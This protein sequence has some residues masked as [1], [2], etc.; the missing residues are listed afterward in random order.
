MNTQTVTKAPL[1]VKESFD[2][3][4]T[5]TSDSRGDKDKGGIANPSLHLLHTLMVASEHW[6]QKRESERLL[7]WLQGKNPPSRCVAVRKGNP[8]DRCMNHSE[9]PNS[10]CREIHKCLSSSAGGCEEMRVGE[11][12][13]CESHGC[14]HVIGFAQCV[15][16]R[17]ENGL[18]C[19]VHSCPCCI[20]DGDCISNLIRIEGSATCSRHRCCGEGSPSD[21]L[22]HTCRSPPLSPHAYCEAHLCVTCGLTDS[23]YNLPRLDGSAFCMQHKCSAVQC[24]D[25]RRGDF[26]Y[27]DK[28]ICRICEADS[29]D[30]QTI[31][32]TAPDSHICSTHRCATD[33]CCNPKLS[34]T[35]DRSSAFCKEHT[36]RVC[37]LS[38]EACDRPV[39]DEYPRNVCTDHPLCTHFALQG[40]QCGAL[41]V[42]P[43]LIKCAKHDAD[44]NIEHTVAEAIMGD[45]QCWGIAK[46]TH[47]RCKSTGLDPLGGQYWCHHHLAQA[48]V[49]TV[50]VAAPV[51]EE[52]EEIDEYELLVECCQPSVP[53]PLEPLDDGTHR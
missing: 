50:T 5:A 9:K 21:I 8:S 53:H 34:S 3:I 31:D 51:E 30:P 14:T 48:P 18:F 10:L 1:A 45:G 52:V 47:N 32:S 26:K 13:F 37:F 40:W 42:P 36:C 17:V 24:N 25:L 15:F 22:R 43:N 39:I 20:N 38:G 12:T 4:S 29:D 7:E 44:V 28:H 19:A 16:E 27:C 6:T 46:K 2:A 33:D 49:L 23:L 11:T 35:L 41:A